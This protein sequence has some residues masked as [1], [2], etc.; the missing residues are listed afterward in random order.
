MTG[1]VLAALGI[2]GLMLYVVRQRRREMGV[3]VALGVVHRGRSHGL[4]IAPH[5][6]CAT[7]SWARAIGL[8]ATSVFESRWLGS[9]LFGVRAGDPATVAAA[10]M[11]LIAI[12]AIA[13]WVPGFRAGRTSPAEVL[14]AE[15]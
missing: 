8:V 1:V 7:P 13:C 6:G 4:V 12:A 9:L 3:R 15:E 14:R 10:I 5:V 11:A 2:F